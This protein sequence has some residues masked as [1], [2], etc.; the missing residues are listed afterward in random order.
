[1]EKY[2]LSKGI[3]SSKANDIKDFKG[4]GKVAWGFILALYISQ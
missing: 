1:M 4:L 3:D 2:I